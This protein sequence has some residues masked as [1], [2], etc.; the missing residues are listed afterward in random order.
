MNKNIPTSIV[1]VSLI[2]AL[3]SIASA[4]SL[5]NKRKAEISALRDQIAQMEASR[6]NIDP[7]LLA[8]SIE[9]NDVSVLKS[10]IVEK[11]AEL[12]ALKTEPEAVQREE[13]PPRESWDDRM[14][15][16]K[17]EEPEEYA[18]MVKRREE[19]QTEMRYNLAERT[20]TFLDLDTSNMTE[21]ELANHNLLVEKMAS[22]W[23]L[24]EQFQD[25][26]ATPDR[27]AM[28][29]LYDI[30]QEVRPLMRDERT[31]MFKQLGTDLGYEGQDAEN[32]ASHVEEII[33]ATSLQLPGG[34]RGGRGGGGR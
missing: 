18:E 10:M 7:V 32:F 24:T 26:E 17:E 31:I 15:R 27:E 11:D 20:A 12:V 25:P 9:T 22:V 34:G 6:L 21:E 2:I 13:R 4:L 30:A 28:R 8:E 14:A 1:A 33:G 29:E 23:E 19:R 5:S 3:V 16:M